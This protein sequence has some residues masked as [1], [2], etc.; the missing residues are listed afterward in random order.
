MTN[1]AHP[2]LFA[3]AILA[4][5]VP[6]AAQSIE[7]LSVSTSGEAANGS[8]DS[9]TRVTDDGRFAA[10]TTIATNLV[11]PDP[12]LTRDVFLRDRLLGTT[13]RVRTDA[14]VGDLTPDGRLL[15]YYREFTAV[16]AVVDLATNTE[17]AL[18]TPPILSSPGS[19]SADGR[20]L[21]YLRGDAGTGGLREVVRRD[22]AAA[23]DDLVS[24][25]FNGT[26]NTVL[27]LPGHLS[28]DGSLATFTTADSQIV[29][30]DGN[31]RN[32]AF[33]KD[34]SFGF[35]DR[36]SV[37]SVGGELA[38]DSSAG[39]FTFDT[40]YLLFSTLS[41]AL[42]D[43]TNGNW[44]VYVADRYLGELR[45]ASV[46]TGGSEG[47]GS[48]QSLNAWISAD[49]LRVVFDS[50]ASNL[51]V[52]DTNNARDVFEHDFASGLTRRI[53]LGGGGAQ[54]DADIHLRTVSTDGRYITIV[55]PASNLVAGPSNGE[56]HAYLVDLGP[57]CFVVNYCTAQPNST[58]APSVIQATGSA[59]LSQ[60]NFVLSALDLPDGSACVFFHGTSRLEPT[61][62]FG[63]GL[64]CV[65]GTLKRLGALQASDGVVIQFQD[66][67]S[68]PYA[69]V[70]PGDVRRFQ[71]LYRD[72]GSTSAG[73][74][75]TAAVEVTF[76]P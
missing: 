33:Y 14:I 11:S 43:D 15:A 8:V 24:A 1:S 18:S 37:D 61:V 19:F 27:A 17:F 20:F 63:D 39:S 70:Q 12:T 45:R 68:L 28:P 46:G 66:L 30:G 3:A 25:T 57:Q 75:T 13:T 73:F 64:R 76:C 67:S 60:S 69:N 48:S 65:G 50:S 52:G 51:V 29:P 47:N 53:V 10:F 35:T 22:I 71:L 4:I 56:V 23:V 6:A 2:V 21:L 54:P 7:R 5:A 9:V 34:Y 26:P 74:N 38:G 31:G 62:P 41:P 55:S 36:I 72:S 59:S 58:G 40:R 44:D 42:A 32:D 49:G 16:A